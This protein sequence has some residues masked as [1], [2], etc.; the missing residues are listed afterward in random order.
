[1]LRLLARCLVRCLSLLMIRRM[2][3]DLVDLLVSLRE[4]ILGRV[5]VLRRLW[6]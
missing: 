6:M 5:S 1:M 2:L 4:V 3:L